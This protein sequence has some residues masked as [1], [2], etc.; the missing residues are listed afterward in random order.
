MG[1]G[2]VREWQKPGIFNARCL[3]KIAARPSRYV[4]S[5]R[6]GRGNRRG[7]NTHAAKDEMP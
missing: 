3:I 1:G 2:N 5:R 6:L 7:K 4:R